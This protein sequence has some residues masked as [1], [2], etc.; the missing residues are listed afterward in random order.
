MNGTAGQVQLGAPTRAVPGSGL[1]SEAEKRVS[2]AVF[3]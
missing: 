3:L 2:F 1:G